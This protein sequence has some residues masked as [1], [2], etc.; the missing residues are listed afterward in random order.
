MDFVA[1]YVIVPLVLRN[2]RNAYESSI[3]QAH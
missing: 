2:Y 3:S 1:N